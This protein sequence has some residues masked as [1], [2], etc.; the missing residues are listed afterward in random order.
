MVSMIFDL[1]PVYSTRL[2]AHSL[3]QSPGGYLPPG[4]AEWAQPH[5]VLLRST[6]LAS[7]GSERC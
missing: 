3:Y 5:V 1:L 4:N 2:I 7:L 6:P